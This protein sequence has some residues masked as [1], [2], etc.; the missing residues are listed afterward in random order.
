ML[1]QELRRMEKFREHWTWWWTCDED[2]RKVFP[3]IIRYIYHVVRSIQLWLWLHWMILWIATFVLSTRRWPERR[4][5]IHI[6]LKSTLFCS[7]SFPLWVARLS[8]S[9]RVVHNI[10]STLSPFAWIKTVAHTTNKSELLN[11]QKPSDG[12]GHSRFGRELGLVRIS[13]IYSS[14]IQFEFSIMKSSRIR[15]NFHPPASWAA[16]QTQWVFV[17]SEI[18]PKLFRIQ[19]CQGL[20]RSAK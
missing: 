19:F 6:S 14:R 9:V 12:I 11:K 5:H 10:V 7:H 17:L 2:K 20:I 8:Q 1:V 15:I 13:Y 4:E 16:A 3:P 18:S